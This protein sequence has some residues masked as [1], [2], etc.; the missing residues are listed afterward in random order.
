MARLRT[1]GEELDRREY[2]DCR[3]A[4][5][6]DG[7]LM[8]N[9]GFGWEPWKRLKADVDAV[10]YA[11]KLRAA[12]NVRPAEFH[13]YIKAL[14]AACDLEHRGTLNALVDQMPDDP[15]AVLSLF[16]DFDYGLE[17]EDVVRCCH[18]RKALTAGS[19]DGRARCDAAS[20]S[21]KSLTP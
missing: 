11:A 15:D 2:A 4:V 10:A 1:H 7:Y 13:S 19:K 20:P 3:V 9:Q 8:R 14:V 6:S 18:A 5:M 12:Y 21:V 17:I 16:D